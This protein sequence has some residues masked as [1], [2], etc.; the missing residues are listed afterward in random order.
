MSVRA[1]SAQP[2]AQPTCR[3]RRDRHGASASP[4][5]PGTTAGGTS[6]RDEVGGAAGHRVRGVLE[7]A[8]AVEDA[9]RQQSRR[10]IRPQRLGGER[11]QRV[12]EEL[13]VRVDERHRG[14]SPA[15]GPGCRLGRNRR[16]RPSRSPSRPAAPAPPPRSRRATRSRPRSLAR[17]GRWRCHRV[18]ERGQLRR[19]IMG[20]G[21]QRERLGRRAATV[22]ATGAQPAETSSAKRRLRCR[23]IKVLMRPPATVLA[24]LGRAPAIG[25]DVH[26]RRGRGR[27]HPP[28]DTPRRTRRRRSPPDRRRP[29]PRPGA[30]PPAPRGPPSRRARAERSAAGRSPARAR[31]A[32]RRTWPSKETAPARSGFAAR[33][34]AIPAAPCP[35]P[36]S[37]RADDASRSS[38]TRRRAIDTAS[39]ARSGRFQ[40]TRAPRTTISG[41]SAGGRSSSANRSSVDARGR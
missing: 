24:H 31:R 33:A 36:S 25:H 19:R 23:A 35:A 11:Q 3:G 8:V 2:T 27:A 9:R 32:G 38:G 17:P 16:S 39:S 29:G 41:G 14:A 20:D 34:A 21:H 18:Q 30:P 10:A 1:T 26:E 4:A 12:V 13:H 28:A 15:P 22:R 6:A 7:A 40:S 37:G 5:R